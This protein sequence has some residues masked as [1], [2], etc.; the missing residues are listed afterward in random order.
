VFVVKQ[1][2]PDCRTVGTFVVRGHR[3]LNRVRFAGRVNG[4][5][6]TPGTYW[7]SPRA[8]G[9]RAA[10]HVTIVV[11]RT[12]PTRVQLASARAANACPALARTASA[13]SGTL[14]ASTPHLATGVGT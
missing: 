12:A 5:Q 8:S 7:I 10:N 6:L 1:V 13:S 9:I 11:V 2:S 14:I 4:R 3:G